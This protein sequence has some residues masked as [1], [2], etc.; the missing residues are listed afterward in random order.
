MKQFGSIGFHRQKKISKEGYKIIIQSLQDNSESS[1]L[2]LKNVDK[3]SKYLKNLHMQQMAYYYMGDEETSKKIEDD[4]S[5]LIDEFN[6]ILK[7]SST[8]TEQ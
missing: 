7:E 1:Q 3:V 8:Q 6:Q 4:S 5:K 2:D